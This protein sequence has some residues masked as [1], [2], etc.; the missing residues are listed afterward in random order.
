MEPNLCFNLL[1]LQLNELILI[2]MEISGVPLNVN[3]NELKLKKI[4][5]SKISLISTFPKKNSTH[6]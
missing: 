1:Q 4:K 2:E 5:S 3:R 6:G